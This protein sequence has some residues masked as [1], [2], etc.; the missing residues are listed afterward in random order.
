MEETNGLPSSEEHRVSRRIV[1]DRAVG[2]QV[3]RAVDV[4]EE[5]ERSEAW[6]VR[7][8]EE[9]A[10]AVLHLRTRREADL[11]RAEDGAGVG[12]Q[13]RR[14]GELRVAA[15]DESDVRAE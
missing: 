5:R 4:R 7:G 9:R 12:E 11:R 3:R 1:D 15:V 2:E 6:R 13:R 8:R 14:D 10:D